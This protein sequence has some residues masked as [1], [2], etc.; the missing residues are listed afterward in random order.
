MISESPQQKDKEK[1]ENK[2]NNKNIDN[3]KNKNNKNNS[4]E[5]EDIS[6][7]TSSSSNDEAEK[8]ELEIRQQQELKSNLVA[9]FYKFQEESGNPENLS[10]ELGGNDVDIYRFYN[11]V[12]SMGGHRSVT[13]ENKW[14]KVLKKLKLDLSKGDVDAL[15][16]K[17]T[18]MRYFEKFESFMNKLGNSSLIVAAASSTSTSQRNTRIVR[19]I[20]TP[21][22]SS[23]DIK[24]SKRSRGGKS[25]STRGGSSAGTLSRSRSTSTAKDHSPAFSVCTKSSAKSSKKSSE[26]PLELQPLHFSFS[27]STTSS[28]TSHQHFESPTNQHKRTMSF[29]IGI[30]KYKTKFN[31]KSS[32]LIKQ[33]IASEEKIVGSNS[34][35]VIGQHF[36]ADGKLKKPSLFHQT[37]KIKPSKSHESVT[38]TK[39][40]LPTT[41]ETLKR[42]LS[43]F[44][45]STSIPATSGGNSKFFIK[46]SNIEGNVCEVQQHPQIITKTSPQNNSSPIKTEILNSPQQQ[47]ITKIPQQRGRKPKHSIFQQQQQI[48]KPQNENEIGYSNAHIFTRFYQGQKVS[49]RHHLRFYD[50]RVITVKQPSLADIARALNNA[51]ALSLITHQG[52]PE[53]STLSL[54]NMGPEL[55]DALRNLLNSTKIFVHYLG[56]NSR[57]DEW[58]ML[59]KIRVDEKDERSSAQQVENHLIK[60]SGSNN[61][62][63]QLLAA[64]LD[65]CASPEG[66]PSLALLPS[67]QSSEQRPRRLSSSALAKVTTTTVSSVAD[68]VNNIQIVPRRQSTSCSTSTSSTMDYRSPL[69]PFANHHAPPPSS[70]SSSSSNDVTFIAPLPASH[71]LGK[72]TI[73]HLPVVSSTVSEAP[74]TTC[75]TTT[76]CLTPNNQINLNVEQSHNDDIIVKK[77]E[78][79]VEEENDKNSQKYHLS[80]KN[81]SPIVTTTKVKT[82]TSSPTKIHLLSNIKV[83]S[84]VTTCPVTTT[85][86][87]TTTTTTTTTNSSLSTTTTSNINCF[88]QQ[89]QQIV[90]QQN[91]NNPQQKQFLVDDNKSCVNVEIISP[92]S[93]SLIGEK[94]LLVEPQQLLLNLTPQ[95]T[96][97]LEE[98]VKPETSFPIQQQY[99]GHVQGED[100]S[101]FRLSPPPAPPIFKIKEEEKVYGDFEFE[102]DSVE[103]RAKITLPI[104]ECT[105]ISLDV[106]PPKNSNALQIQPPWAPKKRK[107][108]ESIIAGAMSP[109]PNKLAKNHLKSPVR[110]TNSSATLL[111]NFASPTRSPLVGTNEATSDDEEE[112][113]FE[114]IHSESLHCLRQRLLHKMESEHLFDNDDFVGL[115]NL[116]EMLENCSEDPDQQ[117]KLIEQRMRELHSIFSE[118]KTKL[119][120]LEKQNRRR[121]KKEQQSSISSSPAS[122]SNIIIG[123]G[124]VE[125]I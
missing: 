110:P 75:T 78:E 103:D 93:S 23:G 59:H 11:V 97:I 45:T 118:N 43:S 68:S 111:S 17:K 25:S 112:N 27:S 90:S 60:S 122:R 119:G 82:F 105:S 121:R 36:D 77:D 20:A 18:Y 83:Y 34:S 107:S 66:I 54:E 74:S 106:T 61:L 81:I 88:L 24:Q 120:E 28:S 51:F 31:K 14:S 49:A 41:S 70:S 37:N 84:N 48:N 3:E 16:V 109:P 63:P 117:V 95:Q 29:N 7:S 46:K 32:P 104:N 114:G 71:S 85:F 100:N 8:D 108:G 113:T 89:Q 87:P 6:S 9:H 47:N 50:A 55:K 15:Q 40:N 38:S 67:A 115:P 92:S 86:L 72:F 19:T 26:E 62:P 35:A 39:S 94:G 33:K 69:N 125:N 30:E 91:D 101:V 79:K 4:P 57:Y 123:G 10:P 124:N 76:I 42:S 80:P 56:W 1:S 22:Q 73:P 44:V 58:L 98:E 12:K 64:A 13:K 96:T 102:K 99:F 53:I 116:D 65:W 5:L 2:K 21:S 52:S